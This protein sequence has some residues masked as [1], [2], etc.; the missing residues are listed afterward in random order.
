MSP[1]FVFITYILK[2]AYNSVK[3]PAVYSKMSRGFKQNK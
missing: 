3:I 1:S 2:K